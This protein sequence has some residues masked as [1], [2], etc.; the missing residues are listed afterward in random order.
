M[1]NG[2]CIQEA[3]DGFYIKQDEETKGYVLRVLKCKDQCLKCTK[4]SS[5]IKCKDG[6]HLSEGECYGNC[7]PG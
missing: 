7:D 5:C 4:D 1:S 2:E 6:F 3:P